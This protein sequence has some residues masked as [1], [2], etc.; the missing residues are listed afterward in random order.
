MNII[1]GTVSLGAAFLLASCTAGEKPRA[2]DAIAPAPAY[3]DFSDLRVHF[4]AIPTLAMSEAVAR[5]YNVQRDAEKALMTVALRTVAGNE[6]FAAEG[7]VQAV[8]VDLQGMRQT[9]DFTP[10][11]TGDYTDYIGTFRI[12]ERDSYRFEITVKSGERGGKVK[13]QRN[14]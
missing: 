11:R 5:Q 9:I 12:A 14:F 3:Q 7:E 8:A 10:A 6:E 2:A 13:F 1:V 4:N